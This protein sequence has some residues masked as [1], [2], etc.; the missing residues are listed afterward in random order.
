MT[1]KR[2]RPVRETEPAEPTMPV[3]MAELAVAS[4]TT[5]A[6]RTAMAATGRCSPAEYGSMIAEKL[7]AMQ[8]TALASLMPGATAVSLLTPWHSAAMRNSERLGRK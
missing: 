3:M 5:I 2:R 7:M 8:Q 1:A 4:A 6:H